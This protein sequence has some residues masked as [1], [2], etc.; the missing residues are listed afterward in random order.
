MTDKLGIVLVFKEPIIYKLFQGKF[1]ECY[2][3]K[4]RSI[5]YTAL[6]SVHSFCPTKLSAMKCSTLGAIPYYG[7]MC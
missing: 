5:Q 3:E 7:H 4:N 2:A 6:P 1:D